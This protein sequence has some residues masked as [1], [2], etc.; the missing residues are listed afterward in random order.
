MNLNDFLSKLT[1]PQLLE[2]FTFYVDEIGDI[3]T[4]ETVDDVPYTPLTSVAFILGIKTVPDESWRAASHLGLQPEDTELI[5][6]ACTDFGEDL[7]DE[8]RD[9]LSLREQILNLLME[10]V[11]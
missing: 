10:T 3:V 7:E 2:L 11:K 9:F 5:I 4:R 6:G 1:S 8:G